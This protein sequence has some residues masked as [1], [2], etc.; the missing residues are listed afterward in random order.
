MPL[1]DQVVRVNDARAVGVFIAELRTA[2][3][4]S[5]ATGGLYSVFLS[6]ADGRRLQVEV[7]LSV[8]VTSRGPAQRRAKEEEPEEKTKRP[9]TRKHARRTR[10]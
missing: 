9:E 6:I 10:V 7:G 2:V 4:R 5:I 8:I 3:K 1:Q